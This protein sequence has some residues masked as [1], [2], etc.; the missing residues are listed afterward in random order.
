M[1]KFLVKCKQCNKIID[2]T[3]KANECCCGI[4]I[5]ICKDCNKEVINSDLPK[6]ALLRWEYMSYID[7]A[8]TGERLNVY[9]ERF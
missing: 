5:F 6:D 8:N 1:S 2:A 3:D 7:Y 4:S 9:I